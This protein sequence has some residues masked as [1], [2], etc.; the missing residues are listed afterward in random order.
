MTN[1][2]CPTD[3][4]MGDLESNQTR[5]WT[6]PGHP[7]QKGVCKV[8]F[9]I[10]SIAAHHADLCMLPVYATW[11][12]PACETVS[13]RRECLCVWAG[14]LS[15]LLFPHH[16]TGKETAGYPPL[17]GRVSCR[18]D[19]DLIFNKKRSS[20]KID[21]DTKEGQSQQLVQHK[22][23]IWLGVALM[24]YSGLVYI[25]FLLMPW[26]PL[27]ATGKVIL[28]SMIVISGEIAAW[29]STIILGTRVLRRYR[30]WLN[31]KTWFQS[32]KTIQ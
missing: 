29:S 11:R 4:R 22:W 17:N 1:R 16:K 27:T 31:P 5:T 12:S 21:G 15:L 30:R 10:R 20:I 13:L 9:H 23:L 14:I 7:A 25:G 32:T 6:Y 8:G 2:A 26:L 19:H 18:M 3:V 28:G 24:L